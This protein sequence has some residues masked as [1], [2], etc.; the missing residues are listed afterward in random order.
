M[1]R[2]S[3]FYL[4][5]P[6]ELDCMAIKL[7]FR[8]S[9]SQ[10]EWALLILLPHERA[11]LPKL[12]SQLRAPGQLAS[13]MGSKFH[14]ES[15]HFYLPKFKLA[16]EPM[17]DLKPI[18]HECGMKKLFGGGDLSRLSQS[19]LSVTDAYHKA[20]LELDEEGVTAAA[21]TFFTQGLSTR[22]PR[23][24]SVDHP[25]FFTLL[26]DSAVPVFV[27]HVVAPKWA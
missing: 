25:F 3:P 1:Y 26:C 22:L 20:V 17:I 12:I 16:D 2:K 11:G 18:L 27:G 7:P 23:T 13:A 19:C 15:A 8:R 5:D 6:G 21:A 14:M 24:I 4:T 9:D 10:S